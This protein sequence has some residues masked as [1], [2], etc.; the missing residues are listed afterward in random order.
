MELT[1]SRCDLQLAHNWMVAS[2]Q[3]SGGKRIY[4]SM[5]LQLRARDGTIGYGEASPSLRYNET[6]DTCIAFARKVDAARLSFDDVEGSM[7]YVES[8]S[9]GDFSPKGAFNVAL[10]DGAAKKARQP[11]HQYLG[12]DF[13]EGKHASSFTIGLDTPEM[14][15]Q[16]T[17]EAALLPILKVKVGA[18]NDM[19][20]LAAVRSVAPQKKLRVDANEAWL[21]KEEALEHIESLAT[22][23]HLEYIEQPMPSSHPDAD[24]A[25]LKARS[26]LPIVGD[27]SYRNAADAA[28]CAELFHGVNVKLCKTGGVTRGLE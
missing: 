19:A 6:V 5:L 13:A 15:R 21:T 10:L 18:P 28:R 20:N 27:E 2:S 4:P 8:L 23:P 12:L 11:L 24:F 22:D 7:R 26:P 14:I 1:F 9:P 17:L 25:W 16:K 3:A